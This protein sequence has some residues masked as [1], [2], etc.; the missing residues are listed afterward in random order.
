MEESYG[1][2]GAYAGTAVCGTLASAC[3]TVGY[4]GGYKI[5]EWFGDPRSTVPFT[6]KAPVYFLAV[7]ILEK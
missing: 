7:A 3:A 6:D 5:G 2:A 1:A 4:I